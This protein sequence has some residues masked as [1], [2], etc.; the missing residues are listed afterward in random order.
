ML[1][2]KVSVYPT[3]IVATGFAKVDEDTYTKDMWD[4]YLE[5]GKESI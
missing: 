1:S 4:F 5:S 2:T 3:C